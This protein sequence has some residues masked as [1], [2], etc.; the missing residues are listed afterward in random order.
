MPRDNLVKRVN[1][2]AASRERGATNAVEAIISAIH[3][4]ANYETCLG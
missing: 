1:Y 2:Y 3:K 4:R